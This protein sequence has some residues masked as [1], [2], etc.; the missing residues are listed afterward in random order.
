MTTP[1]K[2]IACFTDIHFGRSSNSEQANI[3]N[4]DFIAWFIREAKLN[5][6]DTC[7][8]LGDYFDNR[9]TIHVSTLNYGLQGLE[10]LNNAFEKVYVIVGN[11][12]LLYRDKRDV[13]STSFARHLKNIVFVNDPMTVGQGYESMTFLPW[14]VNNEKTMVRKI[15]SRY[16]F[17]HGEINGGFM[18]NAKVVM[19]DHIDGLGVEDFTNCEYAFSGHF[20]FRQA[21]ENVL[22]IGN[23][24]PFNFSDVWDQDRGMMLLEWGREPEFM[25]WP[26]APQYRTM[27]L[28]QLLTDPEK[29]LCRK[30]TARVSLDLDISFEE[31]QIIRDEYISRFDMRKIELIHQSSKQALSEQGFGD[32]VVFQTV[33]QI[34]ID[35]LMSVQSDNYKPDRLVDIYRA[36]PSL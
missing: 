22:Y 3:D 26:D 5:N 23:V 4:L 1:F 6:V 11:H 35:G 12:D 7:A 16:I 21:K 15:R 31:A 13:A 10:M 18:M 34:V 24:F 36:L 17:M 9:H 25:A 27:T 30:L 8:F 19:P 14:I 28:S 32:D 33:D 29:M 20:H 2:K